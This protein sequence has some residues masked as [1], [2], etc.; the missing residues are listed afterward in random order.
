METRRCNDETIAGDRHRWLIILDA[1][2]MREFLEDGRECSIAC[3]NHALGIA[4]PPVK[5]NRST[6]ANAHPSRN[7]RGYA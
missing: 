5:Q 7:L 3:A 6:G 2:S 1:R 4:S